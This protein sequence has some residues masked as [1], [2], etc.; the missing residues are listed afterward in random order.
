MKNT[1][2]L[3]RINVYNVNIRMVRIMHINDELVKN[4][5]KKNVR[6]FRET[7]GYTQIQISELMGVSRTTYTKWESGDTLPNTI[8]INNLAK[9]YGKS[10]DD[11]IETGLDKDMFYVASGDFNVYGDKYVSE[12]NDE[13]R[14]I[15]AKFRLLNKAD[16][17]KVDKYFD[18]IMKEK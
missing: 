14:T 16:K 18:K 9:L 4:N 17:N 10:V 2:D 12:L 1:V 11:F 3:C 5:I 13:E 15:I 8:Q 7:N 6:L